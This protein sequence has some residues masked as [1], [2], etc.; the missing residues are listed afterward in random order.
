[1]SSGTRPSLLPIL[2]VNFV[3]TLGLSI[4]LPFLVFVVDDWG[5]NALVY[6]VISASYSAFQLVGAPILGRWSVNESKGYALGVNPDGKLVEIV[7]IKD[8][9]WFIGVQFHPEYK[10]T[11]L[12][13]H[14]LFINFVKATVSVSRSSQPELV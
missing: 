10:S 14:P 4:V 12:D 7:E 13:P 8:H 11:V 1:M 5:G 3:G 6:G 2:A 9:P